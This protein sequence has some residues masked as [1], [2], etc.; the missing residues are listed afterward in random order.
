MIVSDKESKRRILSKVRQ[1][2]RL[3]IIIEEEKSRIDK[4][5]AETLQVIRNSLKKNSGGDRISVT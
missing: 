4:S 2:V 5:R 1:G 3:D